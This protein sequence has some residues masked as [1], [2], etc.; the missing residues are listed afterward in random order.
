MKL[1]KAEEWLEKDRQKKRETYKWR[2]INE[3]KQ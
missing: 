2:I 1:D 3:I